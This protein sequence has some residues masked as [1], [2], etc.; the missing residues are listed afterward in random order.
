[1]HWFGLPHLQICHLGI[2]LAGSGEGASTQ[3]LGIR[4]PLSKLIRLFQ[5]GDNMVV[6][7]GVGS[8]AK[9]EKMI[10]N[11]LRESQI[12]LNEANAQMGMT[13]ASFM[14]KALDTKRDLDSECGY[15]NQITTEMYKEMYERNDVASRVVGL[16]PSESWKHDPEIY[17][18]ENEDTKTTFEKAVENLIKRHNV[19]SYLQRGDEMSGI[20]EFGIILLGF[21]DGAELSKPVPGVTAERLEFDGEDSN[22]KT[23]ED[24]EEE[25]LPTKESARKVE[26]AEAV[27]F[28]PKRK[29]LYMRVLDQSLVTISQ[30]ETNPA[31]PRYGRPTMY[32]LT[33][34]DVKP[35]QVEVKL[36][37]V[38][39]T[40]ILHLADNCK[41]NE[42]IG[43]PRQKKVFNR[44]LDI[45]K[46][47]GGSAEMFWKGAFPG[48][49]FEV[50]PDIASEVVFD[51]GVKSG[52]RKEFE[53][54]SNGLQRYLATKGV[55]VKSLATQVADPGPHLESQL[56]LICI[57]LTCP[58]RIFMGSERGELASSQDEGNWD[59]QML[60]RQDKY[61]SPNIVYPFFDRLIMAGCLPMPENP[62]GYTCW[63]PPL[64]K[65]TDTEK[66]EKAS[67]ITDA[68]AK[69]VAGNVTTLV[70]P[71]EYFTNFLGLPLEVAQAILD[72]AEKQIEE[73]QDAADSLAMRTAG[74]PE[75]EREQEVADQE[76]LMKAKQP[77]PGA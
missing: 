4:L 18:D 36:T 61:N 47:G 23:A 37:D 43:T 58:K 10:I 24:D 44:L 12:L 40:R 69:Y 28:T 73:T 38:H 9:D 51:E 8:G 41:S 26:E 1:M 50:N 15:P 67:K 74:N 30:Y 32:Q 19:W 13:R 46:V 49:S 16:Y 77:P 35:G 60:R 54:Y 57:A 62:A 34:G 55:T 29:L 33:M 66:A 31:S 64:T 75:L 56:D 63:W 14:R 6:R 11:R 21:D 25:E 42:V 2:G 3:A 68:L 48:F 53:D 22:Q 59:D 52:L 5:T 7:N 65:E 76:R 70:P 72:A 27:A 17:E 39:W 45:R 20:G 71:L